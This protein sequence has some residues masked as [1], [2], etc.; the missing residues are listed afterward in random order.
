MAGKMSAEIEA[1]WREILERQAGSGQSVR[2]FCASEGISEP[3]F[4]TWRKKLRER[5]EGGPRSRQ[6]R[7]RAK[8]SD[9]ASLFVPMRLLDTAATLEIVH[10]LGYR[11]R[12]TGDVPPVTLR[13]VI[14]ALED[15]GVR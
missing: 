8:A 9:D 13:H 11:I 1:R 7:C 4:Y 6:S 12:V 15:R 5:Q 10:P 14:E 3:S 2:R